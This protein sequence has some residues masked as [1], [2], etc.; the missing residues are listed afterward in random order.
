MPGVNGAGGRGSRRRTINEIN[1][2]PFID[3]MLVLLII[4]MVS[5]PLITTGLVDL[6]SVGKAKTQPAHVIHIVVG[7]DGALKFRKD[8]QA[9]PTPLQIKDLVRR[10]REAQAGDAAIPVV[11]SADR[12]VKYE[13][14]VQVMDR[15]QSA[16]IQRVGLAVRQGK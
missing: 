1:M 11:I 8:E 5:A 3:V 12:Q 14:V 13:S 9:D 4:F 15:L 10:V 16:G 7:N 2:V 6:P